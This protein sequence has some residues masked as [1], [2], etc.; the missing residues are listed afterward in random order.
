MVRYALCCAASVLLVACGGS[1]NSGKQAQTFASLALFDPVNATSP[2]TP[3]PFDGLFSGASTPTLNI[4]FPPGSAPLTDMNQVDGFSTTSPIFADVA[5]QLDYSTVPA[6]IVI[7]NS[8]TG[9]VLVPGVDFTVENEIATATDPL[10]GALTPISSQRSRLY[11]SPLKPL[12][13]STRYLVA[14]LNGMRTVDGGGVI[15]S[16]AF[17]ITASATPVSEQSDPQLAQYNATQL[18]ELEALRSQLIH[19]VVQALSAQIPASSMV[20]AWSF[21]TESISDALTLVAQNA[22]AGLIAVANTTQTTAVAGGFGMADIYAGITTVPYYLQVP[23]AAN[24]AA[25]LSGFWHADPAKPNNAASFLGQIPCGA[26]AAGATVNGVT[27]QPSASTTACFPSLDAS[28]AS[29]Q[30]VPVLVT[31]PNANSGQTEPAGGW[32]VVIFQHG[33]TQ[34][35]ENVLAVADG[36]ARA[37]FVAVAMD[38]PLHGV[39]NT[40]D[41]FYRN[42]LFAGTPAAALITGERTFDLDLE[43]NASGAA[44]PD[45]VIDGSGT[46]F[47]NLQSF[48]TSRDNLREAVADLIVLGKSVKGLDLNGDGTPDVNPNRIYYFGHSLGGIVGGTLLAVDS[49][50]RAAVLANPGGGVAKLLD[51][52]ASFGP[53]IAAGLAAQGQAQGT[54]NFP[55]APLYESFLKFAQT[56]VDS[57]DPINYAAAASVAHAIDM[58]EVIGDQV[59]PNTAL[60]T[61]PVPLPV[62]V[63]STATLITACAGSASQDVTVEP[64][65]LSGTDPLIAAQGLSVVGPVT[66]PLAT[67]DVITG[68]KLDYVVQFAQGE[69]GTVLSPAGPNGATQFL[70]VTEEMQSEAA[71][72]LASDGQCLAVG[73]SCP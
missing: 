24:P 5:G 8:S 50:I 48:I 66:P 13:P 44:G 7:V 29:T 31:V 51:A 19:P 45:G 30:T 41:P 70:A 21:T 59:V 62:G 6:N 49:D 14:L 43:N 3:F 55:S 56:L 33:I 36:L 47:I 67:P 73:G 32:P 61:C 26:F 40:A 12:A 1:G 72:F 15:A 68:A 28:T 46:W 10:S 37:G 9:Q 39:T 54:D 42:Q 20:L 17:N 60:S 34:D 16:D 65:Y 25:P 58:I 27:L 22:G 64:G 4:P 35:R 52:S 38:L 11:I 63:D 18:A 69:H 57:G 53:P 71:Q 23:S 2:I